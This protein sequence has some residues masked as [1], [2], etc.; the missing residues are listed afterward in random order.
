MRNHKAWADW[1][2]RAIKLDREYFKES[3][4]TFL[5]LYPKYIKRFEDLLNG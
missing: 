1:Y 2:E 4:I 5:Y 3:L